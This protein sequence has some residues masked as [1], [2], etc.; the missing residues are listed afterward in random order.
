V[1]ASATLLAAST[2]IAAPALGF[3]SG[4]AGASPG[5]AAAVSPRVVPSFHLM[6]TYVQGS[7]AGSPIAGSSPDLINMNGVPAVLVGDR[8]GNLIH[9]N[10]SNGAGGVLYHAPGPI[11]ST[12]STYAGSPTALF[13][14][15][16]A[17]DPLN[18][19]YFAVNTGNGGLQWHVNAQHIAG[20]SSFNGVAAG[21][22]VFGG[23]GGQGAFSVA[24]SIGSTMYA[25]NPGGGVLP[26]FPFPQP[27]GD[28]STP[29]VAPMRLGSAQPFIVDNGDSTAGVWNNVTY[30]NGNILRVINTS[31]QQV[32]QFRSNQSGESSPAVGQFFGSSSIGIVFGTGHYFAGASDTNKL[33]ALNAN[34]GLV[35][36]SQ[37]DGATAS[38]PALADTLGNGRLQVVEGTNIGGANSSG[39]VWDLNGANG[40][41]IWH[42]PATG[43][44]IG[45]VTTVDPAHQGYQDVLAP[46]TNGVDVFDG[47]SGARLAV[48]GANEGFQSSPLVST[49]PNGSIGVTVAGYNAANAGIVQHFEITGS[50]GNLARTANGVAAH[51]DVLSQ[52]GG[53]PMFHHDPQLSGDAGIT[54]PVIQVPCN[55]PS[56]GP[57][58]Y[59]EVSSDGGIFNFGNL[60]FCGSTGAIVLNE[61]IVGIAATANGG[62]YWTVASDGGMF[63]FGNAP[64]YGSMGGKPLNRPI[65]GMAATADG[66]GYYLVAS[67]GGMFAFGNA[68][69]HG[70]TGALHL[71]R[72]IVGMAVTADGGGY[73]LVASDGGMF[74]FGDAKFYGSMGGK[75]LNRPIVGMA[76]DAGT[77]GYWMVAS[78]GGIFS[79]HAPF[80]GSTGSLKLDAPIVSINAVAGGSGYR[81]AASDGGIFSFHAPFYGSMGGKPL[82]DPVVGLAG[83]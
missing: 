48:L 49:D 74:A 27:D 65:V 11:D 66:H 6:W 51:V 23:S 54:E 10:L 43:A 56:G 69:F 71:V 29:A 38:S 9:V 47:R 2:V 58:G 12:P 60:P 16:N 70:S 15:G 40:S 8:A 18:G 82:N 20:F 39:S 55:A 68:K 59:Y 64:F 30:N 46:T 42:A 78:D 36:S 17:A 14:V 28:F 63:A 53:W 35:W 19:G 3:A 1:R 32:C 13:G 52:P 37:L 5:G 77:G 21:L 73:W 75:P 83:F 72:P 31:G 80:R 22:A 33:F 62:G 24:G 25:I 61:P 4:L 57:H 76:A 45:S 26:G 79:F 44:V 34:C 50:S 7:D 67:D 41:P 81:F